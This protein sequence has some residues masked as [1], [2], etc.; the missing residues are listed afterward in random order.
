MCVLY[1]ATRGSYCSK[2]QATHTVQ[3]S[4]EEM[5][6]EAVQHMNIQ[7]HSKDTG[8]AG[9]TWSAGTNFLMS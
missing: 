8:K 3:H 6:H 9:N 1:K 2:Q 4:I 7:P 5:G